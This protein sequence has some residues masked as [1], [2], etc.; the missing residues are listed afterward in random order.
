MFIENDAHRME[1]THSQD[2]IN[3]TLN[4]G[5]INEPGTMVTFL[6]QSM[7]DLCNQKRD[8][9]EF[10]SSLKGGWESWLQVEYSYYLVYNEKMNYGFSR[11]EP[12]SNV[13]SRGRK[14]QSLDFQIEYMEG[15]TNL[16]TQLGVELKVMNYSANMVLK[17]KKNED[18][19]FISEINTIFSS[20]AS[21]RMKLNNYVKEKEENQQRYGMQMVIIPNWRGDVFKHLMG[22]KLI[23]SE[24]KV[25]KYDR[26]GVE[27]D[28]A[29][30]CY[31]VTENIS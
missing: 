1:E 22:Q 10:A 18:G 28:C 2:Q 12:I 9:I 3:L 25:F 27:D 19:Y 26:I 11:E 5:Q 21:D 15:N 24:Y 16:Q 20:Y 23:D 6:L 17:K 8:I 7:F 14:K 13:S 30:V 4:Q 31:W 29:Y